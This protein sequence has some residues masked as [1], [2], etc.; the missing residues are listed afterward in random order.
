MKISNAEQNPKQHRPKV[1]G[2]IKTAPACFISRHV[3]LNI[4]S[5]ITLFVTG[6][7]FKPHVQ[8]LGV[9]SKG[10]TNFCKELCKPSLLSFLD[11]LFLPR[12]LDS[13]WSE[14]AD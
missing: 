13:D 12:I 7:G 6:N 11:I 8:C 2:E 1:A 10:C 3:V 14:G 5:F 9:L 4:L